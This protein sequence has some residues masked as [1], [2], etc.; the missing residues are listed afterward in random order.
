M[1]LREYRKLADAKS[2]AQLSRDAHVSQV[3]LYYY[4]NGTRVCTQYEIAKRIARATNGRVTIEEL[5]ERR[6]KK[7]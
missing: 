3:S 5:C 1:K 2:I 7:R 4:L 6:S